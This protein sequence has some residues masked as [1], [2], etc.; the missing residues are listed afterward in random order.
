MTIIDDYWASFEGDVD[1]LTDFLDV[2]S[3]IGAYQKAT[4]SRFV[5]R[6]VNDSASILRSRDGS[7]TDTAHS[8]RNDNCASMR[9]PS[10]KR[11]AL[12]GLT[13]IQVGD[14]SAP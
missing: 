4:D 11:R 12:G 3:T 7:P 9:K 2:A 14:D 1:N 5:W 13:G 8:Q 10:S 6:G